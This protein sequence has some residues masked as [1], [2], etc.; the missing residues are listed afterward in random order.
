MGIF[1]LKFVSEKVRDYI[2]LGRILTTLLNCLILYL[3]WERI[4]SSHQIIIKMH[5]C[6]S[7]VQTDYFI[8]SSSIDPLKNREKY[9]TIIQSNKKN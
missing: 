9:F 2:I 8:E 6:E 5:F 1:I 3:E 4:R 7:I